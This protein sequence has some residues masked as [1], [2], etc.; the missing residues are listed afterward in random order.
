MALHAPLAGKE[1]LIMQLEAATI[2]GN[3]AAETGANV[4]RFTAGTHT[5]IIRPTDATGEAVFAD[6]ATNI[7]SF[8]ADN[9][10]SIGFKNGAL[11]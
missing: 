6:M 5:T 1:P 9:G 7:I 11:V 10:G 3:A 2:T 8:F 4:V